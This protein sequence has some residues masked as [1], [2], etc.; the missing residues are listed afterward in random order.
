VAV[1]RAGLPG[2][3]VALLGKSNLQMIFVVS[4][5][6]AYFFLPAKTNPFYP[7]RP[8]RKTCA[9]TAVT[10]AGLSGGDRRRSQQMNK[11]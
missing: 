2:K 1:Q 10:D 9:A 6:A 3:P 5:S 11:L 8:G 4:S 7:R